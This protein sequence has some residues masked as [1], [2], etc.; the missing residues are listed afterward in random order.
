MSICEQKY[1]ETEKHMVALLYGCIKYKYYLI[2]SNFPVEVQSPHEG[3]KATMNQAHP[4][5]HVFRF[6]TAL[7]QFDLI[8]KYEKRQ[9]ALRAD[10]LLELG[11]T[12]TSHEGTLSNEDSMLEVFT[13]EEE[14]DLMVEYRSII[15]LLQSTTYPTGAT[16]QD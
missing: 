4:K 8:F 12:T 13:L 11:R 2:T 10:L 14:D 5:R 3:L 7:Q 1:T 16:T 9:R 6:L 15:N